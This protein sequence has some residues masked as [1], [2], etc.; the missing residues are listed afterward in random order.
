MTKL[1]LDYLKNI[2]LLFII[3]FCLLFLSGI[4]AVNTKSLIK[5][6]GN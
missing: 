4:K 6:F 2:S 3:L 1:V 5:T